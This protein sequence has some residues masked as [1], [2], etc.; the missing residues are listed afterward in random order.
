MS[1][2][3]LRLKTLND[4][5]IYLERDYVLYWMTTARRTRDNFALQYALDLC[6]QYSKPLLVFEALRFD[7][8]WASDRITSYMIDGM[9]SNAERFRSANITYY[10]YLEPE[11]NAGKGLLSS[12]SERAV[13]VVT[14][15]FPSYFLSRMVEASAP[16]VHARFELVDGNG[17]CPLA[18]AP[19]TFQT[20]Y[21]FRRFLQQNMR[22]FLDNFPIED[23][24]Q[25]CRFA[26][27]ATVPEPIQTKWPAAP[28]SSTDTCNDGLI[29][30]GLR[31]KIGCVDEPGG[32]TAALAS[33]ARFLDNRAD[34]YDTD[35]NH[36]SKN[37]TS[38]MSARL[39]FGHIS[40]HRIVRDLLTRENWTIDDASGVNKGSR[41]GWWNLSPGVEGYLDQIIT[42]RELGYVYCHRHP[43]DYFQYESLPPWAIETLSVHASDKREFVYDFDTFDQGTTHDP[44]WNAAQH[45]LLSEGY[46]HNYLRMLW[47]KKIIEW[48][49]SPQ[50]AF[51]YIVE[52][53]NRYALD[54]RN[55]NS[56]SGICWT[57]GRFDRPW[58]PER[59]IFGKI[60]F[61]SSANTARKLRV[62]EYLAKY[63]KHPQQDNLPGLG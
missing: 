34:Q 26:Q 4:S 11:K 49:A 32:E 20:A 21:S 23:P 18:Y 60:R 53:N 62:K 27:R 58:G 31:Y 61:M 44:L 51:N 22:E 36:P 13:H 57:F 29:P 12:L 6:R 24:L 19:R 17:L 40:S 50:D 41:A 9:R 47:G 42:W 3:S 16:Q 35:R 14:D 10:P 38:R 2:P 56:W 55:P 28:L 45:Q 39:H 7:H 52:L 43:S 1:I 37:G 8:P 33:W 48:S 63:N 46:I 30:G 15:H 59:P 5:P 25:N 54:G